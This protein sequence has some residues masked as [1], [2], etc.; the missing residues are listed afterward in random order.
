MI[1]RQTHT[2][3]LTCA[4]LLLPVCASAATLSAGDSVAGLGTDI[5]VQ[6]LTAE[7]TLVVLPPYGGEIV[8]EIASGSGSNATVHLRGQETEEA[9]VYAVTLEMEGSIA[10]E[11][12]F[13]VL[14]DTVDL[15]TSTIQTEND[16]AAPGEETA[17]SVILRDRYG[18]TIADR[19][20]RL[21][22]SESGDSITALS[23]QTDDRGEQQF[24]VE[25]TDAGT[26]T[27]R[28]VDLLSGHTLDAS[29][30]L[31]VVRAFGASGGP[32]VYGYAPVQQEYYGNQLIGSV[33]G[34]A[35]YGQVGSFDVV[36]SFVVDAPRQMKV[37]V[38][39]NLTITAIDRNGN[40]VE[41]YTGTVELASTD[42]NAILPSFGEVTFRGSDLGRKTLVLGLR[43]ATP[44]EQ[45][46][47]AQD[48]RNP[49]VSG[50]TSVMVTGD[51]QTQT[52]QTI[53][54]VSPEQDSMVNDTN[55]TVEGTAQP[56][57]NLIVTGGQEDAYGESDAE[58]KF[59]IAIALNSDQ[60]D[61][62]L[63]VRDESGRNDSGNLRIRL[64]REPPQILKF[65][66]TPS[67]P[68]E[69]EDVLVL[70]ETKDNGRGIATVA[71]E[72]EGEAYPL[73]PV[74]TASGTY[75]LLFAF[76]DQGTYQPVLRAT[77]IAGNER[78]IVST[79]EVRSKGLPQ[80]QNVSGEAKPSA[81]FLQ[82]DPVE[83]EEG[84]DPIDGYRIYVGESAT[85]FGHT[86][87][88]DANT[89]A[90]TI[91]GLKPGKAYSFAVTARRGD[92]E[93]EQ[94]SEI[95]QV[96]ILGLTITVTPG[97]TSL[98]LEWTDLGDD[99]PLASY[100]L[101]YG[102]EQSNLT[103][104]RTING[105]LTT[106]AMR[107]LLN[108]VMYFIRLTPVTTTGEILRDF[109]AEADGTPTSQFGGFQPGP[110]DPIPPGLESAVVQDPVP[111]ISTH[112]GAPS[113]PTT[114][115]PHLA[116]W[117]GIAA[118]VG[119]GWFLHQR[120]QSIRT[121]DVFLRRMQQQYTGTANGN[122]LNIP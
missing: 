4:A 48:S 9:G 115:I 121:T 62:T 31:E 65:T 2:I 16:T 46:I 44:G 21:I 70:V 81:A 38:D 85:D 104:E 7:A 36:E 120:R 42:P 13:T 5:T 61:H 79:I 78:E 23:E 53:T 110:A 94:K 51:V 45:V 12:T 91:A 19:P 49:G 26:R 10:A 101:E 30:T 34:R 75:Q 112:G 47:Y 89:T 97:N 83:L 20:V 56:F 55:I 18:N 111:P 74:L 84:D 54:I 52:Q 119:C 69:G 114:G 87:E 92:L 15:R 71:L 90:A 96:T 40:I 25:A 41:D 93:S 6:G 107:D 24:M 88:T 82:W 109:A 39:E 116:W 60:V 57:V 108:D 50:Q 27:L 122:N 117:I 63:R 106:Y 73:A 80:V 86:L 102:I 103:E 98:T 22:S 113:Q 67:S 17:V 118:I 77:D 76:A 100:L 95:I 68:V 35:L 14:P 105:D 1:S 43:F 66:Y 3:L 58:G 99:L 72:V 29:A 8:Q 64:D 11:T 33:A 32:A 59:S 37:N 28:A